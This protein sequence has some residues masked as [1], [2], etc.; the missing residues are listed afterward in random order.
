V[1]WGAICYL[2]VVFDSRSFLLVSIILL[3]FEQLRNA[4]KAKATCRKVDCDKPSTSNID[5][6]MQLIGVCDSIYGSV[7]GEE[8]EKDVGDVA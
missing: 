1:N 8:E 5:K 7:D 2:S 3:V 4:S 6:M